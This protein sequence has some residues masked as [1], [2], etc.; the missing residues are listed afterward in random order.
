MFLVWDLENLFEVSMSPVVCCEFIKYM[1]LLEDLFIQ[2]MR[3]Q[4]DAY[5]AR[6][7]F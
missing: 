4:I 2:T 1:F 7:S 3:N 5:F 6:V